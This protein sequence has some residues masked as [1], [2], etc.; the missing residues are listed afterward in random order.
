MTDETI[1]GQDRIDL[2]LDLRT[3]NERLRQAYDYILSSRNSV[4]KELNEANEELSSLKQEN[5]RMKAEIQERSDVNHS[6]ILDKQKIQA[7]K[8]EILKGIKEVYNYLWNE[9]GPGFENKITSAANTLKLLFSQH[10]KQL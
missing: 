8:L 4:D 7:E 5:E 1:Y 3:E 2:I 10:D 9:P 6:I